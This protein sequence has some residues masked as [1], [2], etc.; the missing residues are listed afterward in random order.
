MFQW[1][2][3]VCGQ[4]LIMVQHY[5]VQLRVSMVVS[6]VSRLGC[7]HGSLTSSSDKPM[8][9]T[10][11]SDVSPLTWLRKFYGQGALTGTE[12]LKSAA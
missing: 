1:Y 2:R 4:H 8:I 5:Q 7:T 10:N 11:I 3:K 6:N 9:P 12:D